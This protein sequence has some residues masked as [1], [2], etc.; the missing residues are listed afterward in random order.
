MAQ[1]A[2][3]FMQAAQNLGCKVLSLIDPDNTLS[4]SFGE[5]LKLSM[6][7]IKKAGHQATTNED[8]MNV[9]VVNLSLKN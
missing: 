4:D 5:R 9:Y 6:Q 3:V 1:R 2:H 7:E 8:L